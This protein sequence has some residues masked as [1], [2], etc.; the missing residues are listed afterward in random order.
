MFIKRS[1]TPDYELLNGEINKESINICGSV[2][3]FGLEEELIKV[4]STASSVLPSLL[5]GMP[6]SHWFCAKITS[7]DLYS[8]GSHNYNV[9]RSSCSPIN[10]YNYP[11][12]ELLSSRAYIGSYGFIK[13]VKIRIGSNY[14][15]YINKQITIS[16]HLDSSDMP[17]Y[18]QFQIIGDSFPS[19]IQDQT[20]VAIEC[21]QQIDVVT[22]S[23]RWKLPSDL[24]TLNGRNI[25][26]NSSS[27]FYGLLNNEI[28]W[29]K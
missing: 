21:S 12:P 9:W 19:M 28:V 27:P 3:S 11:L 17:D 26:W 24:F 22:S 13:K 14:S 5:K 29:Y 10:G 8:V 16:K 7:E 25:V 1:G 2:H 15:T 23:I 20:Y 18:I 4:G 6:L